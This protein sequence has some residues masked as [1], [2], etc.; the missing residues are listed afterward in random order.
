ML[1]FSFFILGALTFKVLQE[2]LSVISG[3]QVFK[4]TEHYT[5]TMMAELEVYRLQSIKILELCY[6]EAER[7]EEF[8]KVKDKINEKFNFL[9]NGIMKIIKSKLPY[10][11][12][13][14]NFREAVKI[15][16]E[17]N[18]DE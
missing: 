8:N 5:I 2:L 13:Y 11:V 4:F 7:G 6:E 3:Y 1:Y 17:E 9:Q 16:Q 14:D 12:Q 15:L 18:L 10:K